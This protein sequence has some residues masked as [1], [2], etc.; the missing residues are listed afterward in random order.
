LGIASF[1]LALVPGLAFIAL[2][3]LLVIQARTASQFQ[4]YAAG[5]GVLTFMLV[6]TIA[7]SEITALA[8]GIA[9]ALQQRRKRLFASLGIA[10][11]VLVLTFGYVQDI[12]L[13]AWM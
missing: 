8:L 3:L 9:G 13:P 2:V 12:I 7:L 11:C 6:L 10:I 4:E 5:W 1:I